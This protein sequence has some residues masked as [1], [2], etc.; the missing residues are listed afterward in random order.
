MVVRVASLG[1]GR[2]FRFFV[3]C[4]FGCDMG[5]VIV[6]RFGV[7]VL[8]EVTFIRLVRF[9]FYYIRCFEWYLECFDRLVLTE[10]LYY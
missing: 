8:N 9:W 1:L 7:V 3:F 5:I 10:F 2:L 6:L 4:V